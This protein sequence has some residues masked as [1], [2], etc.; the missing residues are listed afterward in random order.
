MTMKIEPNPARWSPDAK[1]LGRTFLQV[2]PVVVSIIG[3]V[4]YI[5]SGMYSVG[6]QQAR[7]LDKIE[8]MQAQ[9]GDAKTAIQ[10]ENK[11]REGAFIGLKGEISPRIDKLE[12]AVHTAESEASAAH[13]RADDMK[14]SL[15]RLE[16]L[17]VRNLNVSESHDAD[18]RATR[19]AVAPK[20]DPGPPGR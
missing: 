4:W 10:D 9:I 1:A 12:T 14:R 17:A 19:N 6:A 20:D 3:G 13:A 8:V 7:M 15:D 5:G 16:D 18:I 2:F 11:Q